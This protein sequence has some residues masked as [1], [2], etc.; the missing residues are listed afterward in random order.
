MQGAAPQAVELQVGVQAFKT[1]LLLARLADLQAPKGQFEAER[2]E[3]DPLQVRRYCG[4]IGQL[5]VDDTQGNP[6]ENQKA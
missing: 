6:W 2:V 4:V 1:D 3:L 5:L